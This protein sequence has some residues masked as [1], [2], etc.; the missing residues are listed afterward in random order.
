[1]FPSLLNRNANQ[2]PQSWVVG[3][4][5]AGRLRVA[6]VPGVSASMKLGQARTNTSGK[7]T[8]RL[9]WRRR[10]LSAALPAFLEK[11]NVGFENVF[12]QKGEVGRGRL[13]SKPGYSCS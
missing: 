2:V 1:M 8:A 4:G 13:R 5:R 11:E 3:S 9:A 7:Q 6:V 12:E 10:L